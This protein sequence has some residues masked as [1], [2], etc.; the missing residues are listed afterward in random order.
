MTAKI[1]SDL[2]T[3]DSTYSRRLVVRDGNTTHV[4]FGRKRPWWASRKGPL[5][6]WYLEDGHMAPV[7]LA[8][9]IAGLDGRE[10]RMLKLAEIAKKMEKP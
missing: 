5:W 4:V 3:G 7:V 10:E 8:A 2:P 1:L 9:K 6:L